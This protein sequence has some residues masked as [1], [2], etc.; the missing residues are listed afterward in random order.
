V[1]V[2]WRAGAPHSNRG[3]EK[4]RDGDP[5]WLEFGGCFARYTAPI[6]RCGVAGKPSD[7]LKELADT[8]NAVIDAILPKLRAGTPASA[9]AAAGRR[10][11]EPILDKIAFHHHYGYS[12][13]LSFAPSWRDSGHYVI[14]AKNDRPLA[15]G[16]VFH[17]PMMLRV[18][19]RFGA[20]FSETV[21]I[22]EGP[23]EILSHQPRSLI[24][25]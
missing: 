20:G 10:A 7:E 14:N 3:G 13:G 21:I 9:V 19:G 5:V 18:K 16:M 1:C 22:R 8:S 23:P 25:L 24:Q 17:L 15:A 4:V 2:G 11:I 12:V 6:M